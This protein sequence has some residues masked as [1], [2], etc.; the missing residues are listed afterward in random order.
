MSQIGNKSTDTQYVLY[1][2]NLFT[3]AVVKLLLY[4]RFHRYLAL[5]K[6]RFGETD[7]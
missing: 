6:T 7:C 1:F 3:T 4:V 2:P 5:H